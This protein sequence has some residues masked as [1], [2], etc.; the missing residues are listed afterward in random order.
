MASLSLLFHQHDVS[1][2]VPKCEDWG[3]D[4]VDLGVDLSIPYMVL[5]KR[6]L[7]PMEFRPLSSCSSY[8]MTQVA[9]WPWRVSESPHQAFLR[10]APAGNATGLFMFGK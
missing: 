6:C 10:K 1:V 4:Q 3:A 5:L 2:D 7:D 9:I 8:T